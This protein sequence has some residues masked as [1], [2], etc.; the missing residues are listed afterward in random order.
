MFL[1]VGSTL[2][3]VT[4]TLNYLA[5]RQAIS[6]SIRYSWSDTGCHFGCCTLSIGC[7]IR[8]CLEFDH[9]HHFP[10]ICAMAHYERDYHGGQGGYDTGRQRAR[11]AVTDYG[12]TMV[13]WM[14]HRKRNGDRLEQER[15][16][17]SFIVDMLPPKARVTDAAWSVPTKHLHSSLNKI[18]HPVNVVKWTPE[19][20]RL[21][22]GSTSGEFTLWNGMG[23]NF[24][25]IS[26]AHDSAI[27]AAEW[28]HSD[29]WLVSAD[30]DGIVKYWQPNFNNVKAMQAHEAPI[31]DLAFSPT[32]AKFVTASDDASLK[33]WDFSTGAEDSTLTGH[34][35][36]AKTVD[37]HPTKGL[38]VSGSKDHQVKL[39]DPRTGRC[40]T[41]LHGHKNTI[42]KTAFD[43]IRGQLLA[44]CARESTARIFDLRMMRDVLLL[45]G[46]ERD[47]TT[48]AWHPIH[49]SLLSTGGMD[50]A[51]FHYLLDEPNPPDGTPMTIS[52][53]DFP[54]PASAPTQTIMPAHKIQHAHDMAV[55]SLDWHP[56]GHILASGSNDRI[57]R[58][59][60]RAR[61]GETD[62]FQ[63]RY[64][65]GEAAGEQHGGWNRGR[66]RGQNRDD[67]DQD[68]D[69]EA[70]ALADQKM[71]VPSSHIPGLPGLHNDGSSVGGGQ[72]ALP[73]MGTA[74][75]PPPPQPGQ[76]FDP[77]MLP[78]DIAVMFRTGQ[79]P[80]PPLPGAGGVG[81]PGIPG[82]PPPPPGFPGL[83]GGPPPPPPNFGSGFPPPPPGFVPPPGMQTP[84]A[85]G[86]PRLQRSNG[87]ESAAS[88]RRRAPLPS[89]QD[90]LKEEIK[91]GN[92][93]RAR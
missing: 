39:W 51:I 5:N 44:S 15:P 57:T 20:R 19:G 46:H 66:N 77:S 24:E 13:Q 70:D 72:P 40:L 2:N 86:D 38:L 7:E 35:W 8:Q 53:Y 26:Q 1:A 62:C 88:I 6:K 61:P 42:S 18:R 16:S 34:G 69:D 92:Y 87:D 45:K 54:D 74:L 89:Q 25:T 14:R 21:L 41:T 90:S 4:A 9:T 50:G 75:P 83:H 33:I 29:D 10:F 37:W 93:T 43:P 84:A 3:R 55:W 28:S 68:V 58:F 81:L 17:I 56:L 85:T 76:P 12:S 48:V 63:D 80:P 79:L 60:S 11:R 64:H 47:I 30:Q 78:P 36:D 59:W 91:R 22:T 31:R 23:F 71:P 65:L 32:D 52:P 49:N 73:G 82:F 27:R 67:D